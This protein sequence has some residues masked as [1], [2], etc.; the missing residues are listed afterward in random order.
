MSPKSTDDF[1]FTGL[2]LSDY[3]HYIPQ[4]VPSG[5]SL[6][7]L[8]RSYMSECQKNF[9]ELH[10]KQFYAEHLLKVR[11]QMMDK[12]IIF[13]FDECEK[14]AVEK[15]KDKG[16]RA[17]LIA[18][19]GYGRQEM[20][21]LSDIDLVFLYPLKNK[22]Y[23]EILTEKMLYILW[24]LGLEVGYATRT[25]NECKKL[26]LEDVTIMTTLLDARFLCGDRAEALSLTTAVSKILKN[27]SYKKKFIKQKLDEKE[28]RFRK[29]GSSIFVLEPNVRESSGGLRD[30]QVPLWIAK[31]QGREATYEAFA[32]DGL[33]RGEDTKKLTQARNF[34]WRIRNEIHL[35]VG[36]KIDLLTFHHQETIATRMGFKTTPDGILAVEKFMQAYYQQAYQVSTLTEKLIRRMTYKKPGFSGLIQR[37]SEKNIDDSFKIVEGQISYRNR[38]VFDDDL[39]KMMLIFKH[40]QERGI[41]IHPETK[42][43]IRSRVTKIDESFRREPEAIKLFRGMLNR[44]K[45]LGKALLA[46]HEVHFLDEWMPEFKE[47]RCRVQHDIYHIYTIDTHSIF[48]VDELS[49]LHEGFYGDRFSD[50]AEV[51]AMI[52][53]PEL[54]TLGIFLHDIGKG[55]GGKHSVRGAKIAAHITKRLEYTKGEQKTI[56]FLI[57]SHL[58]MPHL[59]QRRDLDDPELIIQFARSVETM[60]HL[61]MLFLLT[62]GDIRAIGPDAW[63]DWKGVLLKQ[64]Y[65]RTSDVITHGEFSKEKTLERVSRVK[66]NLMTQIGDRYSREEFANYLSIMPSRYFFATTDEEIERHFKLHKKGSRE[67]IVSESCFLKDQNLH[68]VLVYTSNAPQVFPLVTGVMLANGINIVKADLFQTTDSHLLL[69][70]MVTDAKGKPIKDKKVFDEIEI[71]MKSVLFGQVKVDELIAKRQVPDY[72]EKKPVQ[73]V[74]S[75]I[76]IDNDVSAYYTVIDVYTH[77]RLGL[78]YDITQTLNRLG[79]YVDVSKISTK[80]EQV[81]DVF[82]VKDIFGHKITAKEKLGAIKEAL[83][84]II[85]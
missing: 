85:S 23:I 33:I 21:V 27:S 65:D 73:K 39:L 47:L 69:I 68:E 11:S 56:D 59:S 58:M 26:M 28:E 17:A 1:E 2:H 22:R 24:D 45:N 15:S 74:G 67:D 16:P 41:P 12:L 70:L 36:R 83:Q 32:Y 35:I 79:C 29:N 25:V 76:V 82:Y 44:Y 30:L 60:E 4:I 54:L 75:R 66:E 43:L 3:D 10:R 84:K 61:N 6:I 5:G 42:D 13:L 37:F 40:V 57:L 55:E 72:L 52:P 20:N 14:E 9:E 62:W 34:L 18:Q 19:G 7:D 63:T 50:F 78:L 77:D 80:V 48:A 38:R 53:Q 51:L 49:K 81:I 64:L 8:A 31:I 46:M 71:S